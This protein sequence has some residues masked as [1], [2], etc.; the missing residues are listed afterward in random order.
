MR[1]VVEIV[2]RQNEALGRTS[3]WFEKALRRVARELADDLIAISIDGVADAVTQDRRDLLLRLAE[4]YTA[5]LNQSGYEALAR[6]FGERAGG[7]AERTAI[8]LEAAGVDAPRIYEVTRRLSGGVLRELAVLDLQAFRSIGQRA[9]AD[10]SQAVVRAVLGGLGRREMIREIRERVGGQFAAHGATYA[11]T[12]LFTRDRVARF[13]G[14]R[15]AGFDRFRYT[16]PRD[17]KNRPFCRARVG[18]IY[19]AEQVAKMRN[20]TGLEPV[21]QYG[22]GWNCRHIWVPVSQGMG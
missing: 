5:R 9:I 13:E 8:M 10:I 6:E 2:K 3:A 17:I 7:A 1:D 18:K 4:Q 12:A 11:D 19:T 20:G 16:G 14:A 21:R 22:G 15:L